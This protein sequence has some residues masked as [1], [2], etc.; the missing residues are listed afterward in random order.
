MC[1]PSPWTT[2]S[3]PAIKQNIIK[4][5]DIL[6]VD[7]LFF[8]PARAFMTRMYREAVFGDLNKHARNY[9]TRISDVCLS[10]ISVVNTVAARL[11]CNTASR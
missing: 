8:K 1:W 4:V 6:A 7:H 9:I 5:V 3:L 10:C 2:A 11:A